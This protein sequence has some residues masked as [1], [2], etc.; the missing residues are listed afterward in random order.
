MLEIVAKIHEFTPPGKARAEDISN[1]FEPACCDDVILMSCF[2]APP[3]VSPNSEKL[4]S[5]Q[6]S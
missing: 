4:N 5:G 1:I 2:Y 6:W 3:T